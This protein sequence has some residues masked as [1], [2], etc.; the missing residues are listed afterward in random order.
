MDIALIILGSLL[1]LAGIIGCLLPVLPGPPLSYLGIIAIHFVSYTHFSTRLLVALGVLT[2]LVTILDYILPVKLTK[3][4]GGTQAGIRGS[5]VGLIVGFFV[6]PPLGIIIFPM[7]GAFIAELL[8][9]N[10]RDVAVRSAV[11]SFI[12]FLLSTGIKLSSSGIMGYYF[13]KQLL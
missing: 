5:T 8:H 1:T 9:N 4:F 13:V 10:N 3:R 2:V 7:I 6:F 11:G 12:G